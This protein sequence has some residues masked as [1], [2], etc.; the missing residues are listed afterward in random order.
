MILDSSSLRNFSALSSSV[1][2]SCKAVA[3]SS[4]DSTFLGLAVVFSLSSSLTWSL[5]S[6]SVFFLNAVS[7]LLPL[8]AAMPLSVSVLLIPICRLLC[9]I[10]RTKTS[11][12]NRLRFARETNGASSSLSS[13][14]N[15][16]TP[17]MPLP[18]LSLSKVRASNAKSSSS[19]ALSSCR[20]FR[21][22]RF[23]FSR[24]F[25]QADNSGSV[26]SLFSLGMTATFSSDYFMVKRFLWLSMLVR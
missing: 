12:S 7:V 19:T 26:V 25:F 14:E 23:R 21:L 17:P 20:C 8:S 9:A 13:F 11:F 15:W 5:S 18:Y 16:S 1:R 24:S 22:S 4:S 6:L 2:A 3:D 10:P